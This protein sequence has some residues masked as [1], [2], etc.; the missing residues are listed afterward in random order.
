MN[1]QELKQTDP[2]AI[3]NVLRHYPQ[4][5]QDTVEDDLHLQSMVV[6][7]VQAAKKREQELRDMLV[8][9][10]RDGA[11]REQDEQNEIDR[12]YQSFM[13]GGGTNKLVRKYFGTDRG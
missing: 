13:N 3:K 4:D 9:V 11:L 8:Q 2:N 6:R 7:E 1:Y 5:W 10:A 12:L